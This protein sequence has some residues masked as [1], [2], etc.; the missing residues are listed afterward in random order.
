[1]IKWDS[2]LRTAVLDTWASY[3]WKVSE[4]AT[5]HNDE[6][7][8]SPPSQEELRSLGYVS[9]LGQ[10]LL[11]DRCIFPGQDSGFFAD[12]GAHD[13]L[14]MSNSYVLESKRDWSGVLIE[15]NPDVFSKLN[16]RRKSTCLNCAVS[17]KEGEAEF[18]VLTGYS[19]MLSGLT[20]NYAGEHRDRIARE[21]LSFGGESRVI[22]VQQRRL[23][24]ILDDLG[25][26]D[27][28][29]LLIDTE[30]SEMAV[31]QGIDFSRV[32]IGIIVVEEN[33]AAEQPG[34]FLV[35]HGFSRRI[36]LGWD[37]VYVRN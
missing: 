7:I 19:Q 12:V 6:L 17:D 15:P 30:G 9:Q 24:S 36:R 14:S 3:G 32:R 1:M 33:Y 29:L 4:H 16:G 25:I 35:R 22:R 26:V 23:Q 11:L 34:E 21:L 37:S 20:S 8:L 5:P 10:D 13:G 31:L 28:E 27:L 2:S 18:T